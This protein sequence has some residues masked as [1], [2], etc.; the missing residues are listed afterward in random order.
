MNTYTSLKSTSERL[1]WFD[2][3]IYKIRHQE[4]LVVDEDVVNYYT[5]SFG[6]G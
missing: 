4:Y 3:E 1:E 5:W 2:L 6:P